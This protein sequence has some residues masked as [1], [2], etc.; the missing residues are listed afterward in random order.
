MGFLDFHELGT[1]LFEVQNGGPAAGW[2]ALPNY[3]KTYDLSNSL[4]FSA[5]ITQ[6]TVTYIFSVKTHLCPPSEHLLGKRQECVLCGPH[7][8]N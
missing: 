8:P 2:P 3:L 7:I 5:S 4:P 1:H 6:A